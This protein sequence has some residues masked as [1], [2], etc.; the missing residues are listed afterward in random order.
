MTPA[1]ASRT[2]PSRMRDMY[3][4]GDRSALDALLADARV[5]HFA[6]AVDGRPNVLPTAV[7]K[8]GDSIL[9]HGSTGSR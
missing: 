2:A 5:G 7:A 3:A 1:E 4:N 6:F 8:D 9:L